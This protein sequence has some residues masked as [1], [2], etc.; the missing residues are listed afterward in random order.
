MRFIEVKLLNS[1]TLKGLELPPKIHHHAYSA[2][3]LSPSSPPRVSSGVSI[4]E[5]RAKSM[6]EENA[7]KWDCFLEKT[8]VRGS[9]TETTRNHTACR[10][11]AL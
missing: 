9:D 4:G 3:N 7:R 10:S 6:A 2:S 8:K 1:P 5:G 11:L